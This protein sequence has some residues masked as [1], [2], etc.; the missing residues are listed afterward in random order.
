MDLGPG[1]ASA[2]GPAAGI[3]LQN[4]LAGRRGYT[5]QWARGIHAARMPS[6][7]CPCLGLWPSNSAGQIETDFD[8]KNSPTQ[9]F[10]RGK[11]PPQLSYLSNN[12]SHAHLFL[13][14]TL[15]Q[16][17]PKYFVQRCLRR[18]Y[19]DNKKRRMLKYETPHPWGE[20]TQP[21]HR[22]FRH[23]CTLS[24]F[25]AWMNSRN[26]SQWRLSNL[27]DHLV[28][29]TYFHITRKMI[30]V[31]RGNTNPISQSTVILPFCPFRWPNLWHC[32]HCR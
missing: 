20:L 22:L 14:N 4:F 29:N 25:V 18:S 5:A 6:L 11:S 8:A 31:L 12:S 16:K 19:T 24:R 15:T 9:L 17:W 1:S 23:V 27:I 32:K 7:K 10:L 28:K 3:W 13:N 30:L 2:H 21:S 26:I